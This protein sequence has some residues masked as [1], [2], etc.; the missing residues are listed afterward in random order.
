MQIANDAVASFH[1]SLH[2]E[3]GEQIEQSRDADPVTYLHGHGNLLP[4][5][6]AK[7]E[8]LEAGATVS[9]ALAAAE[10]YGERNPDAIARVPLKH[11]QHKGRLQPGMVVAVETQQGPRQ[12]TV[13]KVGKF[14]VDVDANHP[15]A[16]RAL[17]F[18]VEITEVR[19]ATP[20]ELAHGHAH[21]AGGHHH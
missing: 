15:L 12:V 7:L 2:G 10:A 6:E 14:N 8:G 20:E 11:L 18:E 19:A 16:G 9:V 13:L 1:Y 4:A 17:R 21:G 3:D 5:L